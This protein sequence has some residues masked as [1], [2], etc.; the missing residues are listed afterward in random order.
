[1]RSGENSGRVLDLRR[2][3]AL[4]GY[5]LDVSTE[6][7]DSLEEAIRQ[8]QR[9]RGLPE[10]GRCDAMTWR[11]V[12]EAGFSI[13][14]RVLYLKRPYFRGDDVAWLQTRLGMLGF[15]CGRVDGIY[16]ERTRDA[17]VEFQL[18][19]ALPS[20]GMC[21]PTTVEELR[22]VYGRSCEH[23]HGVREREL[24]RTSGK[25]FADAFIAVF[26]SLTLEAEA[27]LLAGRIRSRGGRAVSLSTDDQSRLALIANGSNVDL[28]TFLDYS[29]SGI[30]VAYYSGFSYVSPA[31]R[32][33][34]EKVV[35]GLSGVG[36]PGT[37]SLRGM[38]LPILRETRMPGV[39]LS[40]DHAHIWMLYGPEIF[41]AVADAIAEFVVRPAH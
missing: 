35:A 25:S 32:R 11:T 21:G 33:L 8:F 41:D 27:E 12:V 13:G 15:D 4:Q 18:N 1:M 40:L 19:V 22:R 17:V 36:L 26:S 29:V 39:V 10:S 30:Q 9:S 24:L 2:R 37:V 16:A 3:L 23:V 7:D 28:V 34:A 20:D 38:T 14:E 6:F 31:G 5:Q